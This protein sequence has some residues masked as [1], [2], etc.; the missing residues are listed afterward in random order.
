[1]CVYWAQVI[2]DG[3]RPLKK[4]HKSSWKGNGAA[5]CE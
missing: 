5:W 2:G 4:I 1:M 3:V